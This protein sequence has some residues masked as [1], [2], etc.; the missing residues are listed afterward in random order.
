MADW[1]IVLGLCLAG[2][3]LWIMLALVAQEMHLLARVR[4]VR[5]WVAEER[6]ARARDRSSRS[7]NRVDDPP[8][9]A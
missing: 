7:H 5:R 3:G 1:T 4:Y 2:A 9:R 6:A 8:S